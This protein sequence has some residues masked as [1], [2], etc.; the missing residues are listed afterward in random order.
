MKTERRHELEKN[1]LADWLGAKLTWAEQNASM[2]LGVVV[3]VVVVVGVVVYYQNSR[4]E[5][6]QAAWNSYFSAINQ[7]ESAAVADD[8]EKVAQDNSGI[9]P[10]QLAE[11]MLGDLAMNEGIEQLNS[12]R[13][14]GEKRLN[15][16]KN[17]YIEARNAASNPL[18][19]ERATLGLARFYEA[20]GLL[21]EALKEYQAL[22]DG[23]K[24]LYRN[25]AA[26]KL[27][28]LNKPSTLQFAKWFRDRKPAPQPT[29]T[30]MFNLDDLNTL[31]KSEAGFPGETK[32]S[33]TPLS[34]TTSA[35]PAATATAPAG[36]ATPPATTATSTK[37]AAA[38]SGPAP[39]ATPVAK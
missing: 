15:E 36:S 2:L 21:D 16:A 10:G 33:T 27:E 4:A 5:R 14:A 11:I 26:R 19:K 22:A 28:F 37:P 34:G 30:S 12:D 18:L 38:A 25:E 1:Q 39:S 17:H 29:G 6:T 8:L 35:S 24:G 3:A 13:A 20:M 31:P 32:R 7:R 9:L 23:E